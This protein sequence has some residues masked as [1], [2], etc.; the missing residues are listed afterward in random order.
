M[1]LSAKVTRGPAAQLR[2]PVPR[3]FPGARKGELRFLPRLTEN[4]GSSRYSFR[5]HDDAGIS[6]SDFNLRSRR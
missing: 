1:V 4:G 2:R 5:T 6:L 3:T